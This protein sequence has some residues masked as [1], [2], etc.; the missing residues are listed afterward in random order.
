MVMSGWLSGG[1][2]STFM[3]Y[4]ARPL[5]HNA[6]STSTIT[7]YGRRRAKTIGFMPSV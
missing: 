7:V 2:R 6:D 5:P 1:N 3:R 4:R